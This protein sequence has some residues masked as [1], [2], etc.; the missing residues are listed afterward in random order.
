MTGSTSPNLTLEEAKKLNDETL[1]LQSLKYPKFFEI[2]VDRYQ[3]PFFRASYRILKQRED[4]EDATQE[5]FIKMYRFGEKFQKQE[6]VEFKSWA[7][8]ILVNTSLNFYRKKYHTLEFL[9]APEDMPEVKEEKN[10]IIDGVIQKEKHAFIAGVFEKM[11]AQFQTILSQ[12]YFDDK[13]YKSIAIAENIPLSTLKTRLFR[14][15]R[16][17]KKLTEEKNN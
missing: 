9:E 5:A 14:A 15:K 12:Y 4:A 13:S 8:K 7:Y 6:G 16:L 10:S 1:L 17:F 11:P 2:L 3:Q